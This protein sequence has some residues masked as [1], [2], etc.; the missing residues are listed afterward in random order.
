MRLAI[1]GDVHG[2]A[3]GSDILTIEVMKAIIASLDIDAALQVGDLCAYPPFPKPVYW[4]YGN[5]DHIEMVNLVEL[6][7]DEVENLIHI[8]TGEVATI[9]SRG[10]RLTISG[11][12]GAYEPLY[13]DYEP[14]ELM[15]YGVA[16]HFVK[17]DIEKCLSMGPVDIFLAHGCPAGLGFG[18]EPDHAVPQ[19]R[20][21]L[22]RVRPHYMFCGHA[23]YFRRADY[24]GCQVYALAPS[25][26]EYY[27][28]DTA[29]D[30]LT[31][32]PIEGL[33]LGRSQCPPVESSQGGT[34]GVRERP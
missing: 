33:D 11:L 27:I 24:L 29:A 10:E 22:D 19:I 15:E 25:S 13:Y 2:Y 3:R 9:S 23:H 30:K 32:V 12:N 16:G 20:Q 34:H 26:D 28:L 18:R 5:R 21:I 8:K 1:F 14:R 7:E 4:I 6:G 31:T 17:A